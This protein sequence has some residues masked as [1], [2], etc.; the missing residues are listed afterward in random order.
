[1]EHYQSSATTDPK[2]A[3]ELAA[4]QERVGDGGQLTLEHFAHLTI[5]ER[6]ALFHANPARYRALADGVDPDATWTPKGATR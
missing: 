3:A 4:A 1:M 2:G 5:A 6:T